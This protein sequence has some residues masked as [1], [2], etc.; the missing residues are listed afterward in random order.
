MSHGADRAVRGTHR[1]ALELEVDEDPEAAEP[2]VWDLQHLDQAL[3]SGAA[4]P[5]RTIQ[6]L[7]ID[8]EHDRLSSTLGAVAEDLDDAVH[9]HWLASA[10]R[11]PAIASALR[12]RPSLEVLVELEQLAAT[13]RRIAD[14]LRAEGL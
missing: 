8:T 5:V 13:T 3:R 14:R 4:T 2:E 7:V 1:V 9:L 6:G 10:Q 12:A 11:W